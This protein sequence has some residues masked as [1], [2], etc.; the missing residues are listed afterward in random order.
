MSLLKL[1]LVFLTV[2][3]FG[4]LIP[5][6][7][8]A[9]FFATATRTEP[10]YQLKLYPYYFCADT[11]TNKD[12]KAIFTD[13]G[14]KRYGVSVGNFYQIGD[15]SLSAVVPL[16]KTEIAKQKSDNAGIGDIQLRAAWLLPFEWA[17]IMPAIMV[18]VPSGSYD[19]NRPANM[20][21]GQMDLGAELYLHKLLQPLSFD[22]AIKYNTRFHNQDRDYTPGNEFSAEGLVTWRLA[23]RLRAGPA[24]NF[25]VGG[26]N[27]ISGKTQ[28]DSGL[29]RFAVGGEIWFGRL[30]NP[31]ISLAVY[32]DLLTR[33]T[34]EGTTVMSRI[35]FQF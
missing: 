18:K 1:F 8:S 24:V 22:V 4:F 2:Q 34:T 23:D 13:M 11:Y 9:L 5:S 15:L 12:G 30:D 21:D 28:P 33:N 26:D 29:M 10:G 7:S 27:K 32:Q 3:L 19:K 16:G 25:L 35:A 6:K 31:K 14:V 17:G 20:G